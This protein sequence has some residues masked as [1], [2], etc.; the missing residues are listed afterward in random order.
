MK[1]DNGKI[2][3][4]TFFFLFCIS[5]VLNIFYLSGCNH[6]QADGETRT[7]E[8]VSE[9]I[10]D[11]TSPDMR[12]DELLRLYERAGTIARRANLYDT[13]INAI[14]QQIQVIAILEMRGYYPVLETQ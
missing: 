13:E 3:V 14:G 6:E 4:G 8:A 7:T 12:Y 2:L 1:L 10:L 9:P 11:L 5:L